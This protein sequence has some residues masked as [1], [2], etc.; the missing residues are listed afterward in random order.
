VYF[1]NIDTDKD[2]VLSYEEYLVEYAKIKPG[3]EE[4]IMKEDFDLADEDNSNDLILQE[5]KNFKVNLEKKAE[6]AV[7][8]IAD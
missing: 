5:Y 8:I 7:G 3:V 1:D 4:R 6:D 2:S